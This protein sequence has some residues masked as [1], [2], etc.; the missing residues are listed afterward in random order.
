MNSLISKLEAKQVEYKIK[1]GRLNRVETQIKKLEQDIKEDEPKIDTLD[2]RIYGCKLLVEKLVGVSK[3]NLETFLTF[4]MQKIFTDRNYIIRLD[5]KEDS[6]RP[7]LELILEED[8]ISQEITDAVGGGILSTLGLL[9]QIYYIEVYGLTK[10]MFIDE[11]LKE[12]SKANPNDP[13]SKDYLNDILAF[14]KWMAEERGYT[15]VIVTHDTSV[16][17]MSDR[18]YV[19][20]DGQVILSKGDE[21]V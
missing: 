12:V 10:V 9:L 8:G 7:A 15:F 14:L 21:H 3:S 20:K 17:D 4:A 6:K 16:V 5:F 13:D 11:G 19:V 18:V 1:S 2:N